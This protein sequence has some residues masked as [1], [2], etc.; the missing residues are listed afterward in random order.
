M[1]RKTK[2]SEDTKR[3]VRGTAG[4][5]PFDTAR[6]SVP[7]PI[8]APDIPHPLGELPPEVV[9]SARPR[10]NNRSLENFAHDDGMEPGVV[11]VPQVIKSQSG[12]AKKSAARRSRLPKSPA[13]FI[14]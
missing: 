7:P 4:S 13:E 10:Q 5:T 2:R 11:N 1:N 14:R 6:H 9:G 8:P 12:A 3:M